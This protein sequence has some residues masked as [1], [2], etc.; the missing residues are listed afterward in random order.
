[1]KEHNLTKKIVTYIERDVCMPAIY[2]PA[3]E[4][5]ETRHC[6]MDSTLSKK[7]AIYVVRCI[8]RNSTDHVSWIYEDA[9]LVSYVQY[10]RTSIR[11]LQN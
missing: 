10:N 3:R 5:C 7:C 9:G 8:A 4:T 11:A 1:M 6:S 2:K